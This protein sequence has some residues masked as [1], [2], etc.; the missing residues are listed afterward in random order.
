MIVYDDKA[1]YVDRG[2]RKIYR[3]QCDDGIL[4]YSVLPQNRPR[5][6]HFGQDIINHRYVVKFR[7]Y[8]YEQSEEIVTENG[9]IV[10]VQEGTRGVNRIEIPE[11]LLHP[12]PTAV[13]SIP[14]LFERL[15]AEAMVEMSIRTN[16]ENSNT[17]IEYFELVQDI[18]HKYKDELF[19]SVS[20]AA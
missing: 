19:A 2:I 4:S 18:I 1:I 15:I 14:D 8:H 16:Y 5:T 12:D 3:K 11:A 20:A 9:V 7:Y 10:Q 13:C 17:C 6:I